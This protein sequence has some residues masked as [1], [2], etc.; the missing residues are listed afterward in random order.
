MGTAVLNGV[1]VALWDL[2][3]KIENKPVH[4]LLGGCKFESL[5]CYAIGGFGPPFPLDLKTDEYYRL[6][7]AQR[8]DLWKLRNGFG[9]EFVLDDHAGEVV[10]LLGGLL[11][12]DFGLVEDEVVPARLKPQVRDRVL[13]ADL[14]AN[15]IDHPGALSSRGFGPPIQPAHSELFFADEQSPSEIS[16]ART[17]R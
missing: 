15:G 1:E 5:L 9:G 6:Q 10:R 11:I 17:V 14:R 3:G 4:E 2:K 12:K 7:F 16:S 8:K 13:Q